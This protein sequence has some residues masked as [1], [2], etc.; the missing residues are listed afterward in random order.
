MKKWVLEEIK[1]FLRDTIKDLE[2]KMEKQRISNNAWVEYFNHKQDLETAII[3]LDR[4][5]PGE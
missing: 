5:F 4:F 1:K 3:I 2:K